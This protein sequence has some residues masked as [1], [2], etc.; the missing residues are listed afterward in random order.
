MT[1]VDFEEV[2][3]AEL[4]LVLWATVEDYVLAVAGESHQACGDLWSWQVAY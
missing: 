2:V 1:G 4:L 3:T